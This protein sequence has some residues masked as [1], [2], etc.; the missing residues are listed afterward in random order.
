MFEHDNVLLLSLFFFIFPSFYYHLPPFSFS[1]IPLYPFLFSF[2]L[3]PP[4]SSLFLKPSSPC[5]SSHVPSSQTD[6]RKTLL[7]LPASSSL[8][9]VPH[10][11]SHSYP[12]PTY[13]PSPSPG[14]EVGSPSFPSGAI[15][16][17]YLSRP[18]LCE[19]SPIQAHSK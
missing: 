16:K 9:C 7:I 5:S 17:I 15:I 19:G 10:P 3:L 6:S 18:N 2:C 1:N 14:H 4:I 13:F 11:T 12:T 8:L